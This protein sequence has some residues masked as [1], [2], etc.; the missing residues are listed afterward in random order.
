MKAF[1]T[2]MLILFGTVL[3]G[4]V[5]WGYLQYQSVEERK[6]V[7]Q[8]LNDKNYDFLLQLYE[9]LT[10]S[11]SRV[12]EKYFQRCFYKALALQQKNNMEEARAFWNVLY[13]S[14]IQ[15]MHRLYACYYLGVYFAE[16]GDFTQAFSYLESPEL[17]NPANDL[18][19]VSQIK[20]SELYY[21]QHQIEKARAVLMTLLKAETGPELVETIK[22]KLGEV[23]LARIFSR[24]ITSNSIDYI[25]CPGDSLATIAAKY[26]TTVDFLRMTNNLKTDVLRP[27]NH[28][29]VIT[30][31]FSIMISKSKNT[32]TLLENEEFFKE[33]LVGTGKDNV[34][35]IG[36]FEITEKQINP[37]WYRPDSSPIPFGSKENVLGTRWMSINYPGYGIHGTWEDDSIGK[38]SSAGCIRLL[39]SDVEE[40]FTIVPV[41]TKIKI[42]N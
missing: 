2:F 3:I 40:L 22:K 41:H 38:Q 10:P 4:I 37:T 21:Q 9:D 33:Y 42:V 18:F 29:K 5:I 30:S 36:E 20:L 12:S 39:N 16:K 15:T 24:Q 34:T 23:N 11:K 32:L 7:L 26:N 27:N 35:P 14:S 17:T 6:K 8:A 19:H 1:R 31:I 28:L 25:V 13:T